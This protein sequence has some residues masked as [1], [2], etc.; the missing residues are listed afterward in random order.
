LNCKQSTGHRP[1]HTFWASLGLQFSTSEDIRLKAF[2]SHMLVVVQRGLGIV[3]VNMFITRAYTAPEKNILAHSV[4]R[5][6]EDRAQLHIHICL[7]KNLHKHHTHTQQV[8]QI[9]K[10]NLER[11]CA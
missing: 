9:H 8:G 7:L 2:G 4:C 3:I 11:K 1:G 5:R 6:V 10:M